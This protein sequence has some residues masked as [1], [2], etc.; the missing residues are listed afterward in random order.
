MSPGRFLINL[1]RFLACMAWSGLWITLALVVL[2]VTWR[3]WIPLTMARTIWGPGILWLAGGTLE[4][5]IDEDLDWDSPHIFVCNHQSMLDIPSAF[6]ALPTPLR[7]VAKRSLGNIPF[8]GWYMRATG[9]ILVER[10]KPSAARRSLAEAGR[11]VREGTGS[12]LMFPEGTRSRD[13]HIHGFKKGPFALAMEAGV[14]IVPVAIEGSRHVMHPRGLGGHPGTIRV[15][16]GRPVLIGDP[17]ATDRTT[18]SRFTRAKMI[19][20]HRS[21]GG[22]SRHEDAD[23]SELLARHEHA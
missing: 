21:L 19:E 16:V 15:R 3:P 2:L 23:D 18:L 12:L 17:G 20:L 7:F 14:P 6:V 11:R 4:V 1:T 13:G 22:P 9:M 8:L 10:G 5:R